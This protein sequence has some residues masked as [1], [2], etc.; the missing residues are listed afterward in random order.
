[1]STFDRTKFSPGRKP[2]GELSVQSPGFHLPKR[3]F[4]RTGFWA[5]EPAFY[6]NAQEMQL[7]H[8]THFEKALGEGLIL[9]RGLEEERRAR[10]VCSKGFGMSGSDTINSLIHLLMIS[11]VCPLVYCPLK[12]KMNT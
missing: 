3:R 11:R 12:K 4:C 7:T 8:R 5:K 6:P 10:V 1:M 2:L 9:E